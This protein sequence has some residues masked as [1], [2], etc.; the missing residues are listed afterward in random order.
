MQARTIYLLTGVMLLA[1]AILFAV[2]SVS[3]QTPQ[4][5]QA[6]IQTLIEKTIDDKLAAAQENQ[7]A[8][9]AP[10]TDIKTSEMGPV[11]ESYLMAN[12]SL[13]Q[14]M[15]AALQEETE[16]AQNSKAQAA[17]ASMKAP[18]YDDPDHVVLGNPEGDVTL[19][20]FFDYNCGFCRQALADV[21]QLLDEDKNV[22]LI[23]KEF[24]ILSQGSVDAAR[25]AILVGR[26][27]NVNYLDFHTQ[28]FASRGQIDKSKALAAAAAL[29][30]NPIELELQMGNESVSDAIGR[31]YQVADALGISSTP[32]F[33]LGDELLR[34]AVGIEEMRKKVKNMRD[35][36]KAT[37]NL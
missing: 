30:M 29:G 25:I 17:L 7:P 24:P 36:G 26:D 1:A 9:N 20:E 5:S 34:G 35:C 6:D 32:N 4:L 15:S 10:N 12:P 31:T 3:Q 11:I 13:L 19:V 14:R 22:R 37:C 2:I 33:I 8:N 18:I 27:E 16:R 21:L 23:L 28:L